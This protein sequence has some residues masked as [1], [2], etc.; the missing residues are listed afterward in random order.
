MSTNDPRT[1]ALHALL[2][3]FEVLDFDRVGRLVAEDAVFEFPYGPHPPIQGREAIVAFLNASMASFVSEMR[4]TVQAVHPAE[5]PELAFAEYA[6][7]GRLT[8]GG[9]YA[10]RY[11]AVLRVRDGLIQGFKEFY[12]PAVIAALR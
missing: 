4:F 12:N 8:N 9:A 7:V 2:G 6:S 1:A 5:D 11:I 3:A 10:N